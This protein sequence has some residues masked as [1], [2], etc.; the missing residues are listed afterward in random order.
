M[1]LQGKSNTQE[2]AIYLSSEDESD[3]T[4]SGTEDSPHVDPAEATSSVTEAAESTGSGVAADDISQHE[5]AAGTYL[6]RHRHVHG[7]FS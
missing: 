4:T 3:E 1:A 2:H 5:E 7:H 6:H